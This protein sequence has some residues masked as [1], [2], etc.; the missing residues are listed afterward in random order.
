MQTQDVAGRV[1]L[2]QRFLTEYP[3]APEAARILQSIPA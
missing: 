3:G 2:D 1:T